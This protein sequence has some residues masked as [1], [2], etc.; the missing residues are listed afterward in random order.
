MK[1]GPL[2]VIISNG[3]PNLEKML[4]SR[5][6]ITRSSVEFLSGIA[7]AHFVKYFVVVKIK[8]CHAE[9][10][11]F[12]GPIKSNPHFEK[13]KSGRTSCKGMVERRSFPAKFWHLSQDLEKT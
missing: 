1:V 6:E 2:F 12:I 5:K 10:G 3:R 4:F 9:Y 7:S 11:V 8:T 13:G